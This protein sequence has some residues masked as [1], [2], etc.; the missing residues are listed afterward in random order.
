VDVTLN[1]ISGT[2]G[3]LLGFDVPGRRR[4][5]LLGFA[6]ERTLAGRA[7]WLPNFLRFARNDRPDGPFGSNDNPL[8][9]FQWGDYGVEPGQSVRY[10]AYAVRGAPGRLRLSGNPAEVRIRTERADDGRNGVYFNRGVAGSQAYARRFGRSSPLGVPDARRWLSRGLEEGLLAFVTR[11]Q[12]EGWALRGAFYEFYEPEILGALKAAK[13]RGVDV[14]LVVSSPSDSG[15]WTE[16]PAADNAEA[17]REQGSWA[18]RKPFIRLAR[19]RTAAEGIAHNK[20]LVLL[21]HGTPRA[22]WTG[23]TN[24]SP[25]ALYG[26]SNLGHLSGDPQVAQAFLDYWDQLDTDPGT[27]ALQQWVD[28]HSPLPD[29]GHGPPLVPHGVRTVFSPRSDTAALDRY[30]QLM[31]RADQAIFFTAPFGVTDRFEAELRVRRDIPRYL[32]LDKA[33]N[34]MELARADPN[35]SIAVGAYLGQPGGYRQFM[36][37][38]LT[39][40]NSHVK[41]IHTKYMVVDPLTANPVVVTGSANFSPASTTDNDENMLVISGDTRVADIYLAEFMRLFTHLRFRGRVQVPRDQ[42]APDPHEPEVKSR[43]HLHETDK[44]AKEY[45]ET[46]TPKARERL[47]FSGTKIA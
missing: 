7:E 39:G 43:R 12:G 4:R 45:F 35:N 18:K 22:V 11:A 32:L 27:P 26:H 41:F 20:F 16:F 37:E 14:R 33:T 8:Q 5:G 46:G 2:H 6:V 31:S 40:L 24:I 1:A 19:A 21:E 15:R 10:R 17:L 38:Y 44:W 9:A 23:S 29:I 42:R 36:Q 13:M 47:L 34:D 30:V 28:A 3:V 25:G